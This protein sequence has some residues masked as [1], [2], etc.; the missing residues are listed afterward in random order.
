MSDVPAA[1]P[2]SKLSRATDFAL[3]AGMAALFGLLIQ[4][5]SSGPKEG[6][7]AQPFALRLVQGGGSFS[8]AEQHGK[9]VLME[10]FASWCGVCERAAPMVDEV[11]REAQ[12]RGVVFVGVSID[13]EASAAARV[14]QS[15]PIAY[16]VA[17]DD[18]SVKRAYGVSLVPTFVLIDKDGKIRRASTGVPS[19]RA[20]SRW[21]Q[22]L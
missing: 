17:L 7:T 10:V 18:G 2:R 5:S 12:Q 9:P 14:K 22:E 16:P 4:R 11:Y 13:D 1:P 20:L 6:A 21:L 3:Y 8:L 15:W 19:R